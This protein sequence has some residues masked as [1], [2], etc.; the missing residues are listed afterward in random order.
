MLAELVEFGNDG[1]VGLARQCDI[2]RAVLRAYLYGRLVLQQLTYKR[3][4]LDY[5]CVVG[6]VPLLDIAFELLGVFLVF[7][8]CLHRC[9]F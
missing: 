2:F 7:F 5:K 4:P 6:V 1:V 8:D 9:S 3:V